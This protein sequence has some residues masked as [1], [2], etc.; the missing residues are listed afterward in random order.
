MDNLT[1]KKRALPKRHREEYN[2]NLMRMQFNCF[3]LWWVEPRRH[4]GDEAKNSLW[5][6]E[7]FGHT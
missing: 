2:D 5:E 3:C 4:I 7:I 1:H 6:F